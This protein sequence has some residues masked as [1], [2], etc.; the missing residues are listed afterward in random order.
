MQELSITE[1]KTI[2]AGTGCPMK[3]I[4]IAVATVAILLP[5][6]A[7]RLGID[8]EKS[9]KYSKPAFLSAMVVLGIRYV[10]PDFGQNI[11]AALGFNKDTTK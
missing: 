6:A 11:C 9:I 1:R 7:D 4:A 3:M 8:K 2:Y 10:F 5:R